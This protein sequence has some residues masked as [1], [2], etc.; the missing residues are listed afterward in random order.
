MREA[1]RVPH[2]SSG[3]DD[4][5]GILSQLTAAHEAQVAE[6]GADAVAAAEQLAVGDDGAADAG[7][8]RQHDHVVHALAR[9]EA[10][11]APPRGV[12]VVLD[13]H[14][15]VQPALEPRAQ[16]LVA[17]VDVGRVD[18]GAAVAADESGRGDADRVDVVATPEVLGHVDDG[19]HEG[20]GIDGG[21]H[22]EL[23]DDRAVLVDHPTG[24]LRAADV[25]TDVEHRT[26]LLGPPRGSAR[27]SLATGARRRGPP[28][29]PGARSEPPTRH[30][31]EWMDR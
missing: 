23:L 18:D 24:D 7:T 3:P 19:I 20:D 27:S 4:V 16:G 28:G 8:H 17:P 10:V 2:L 25:D 6:L 31:L 30:A 26:P 1:F 5:S 12:G 11:L 14:R 21:V 9:A 15:R 29:A 13:R 22:P